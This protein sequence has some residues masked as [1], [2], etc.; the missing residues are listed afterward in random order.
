[1][2]QLGEDRVN[3]HALAYYHFVGL[4]G[5]VEMQVKQALKPFGLTHE[6]LN[7]LYA[8]ERKHPEKIHVNP[9]KN[10]LLVNNPDITRILDR[11]ASK[12]YLKREICPENRRKMDVSITE[13]GREVFHQ[14]H[15][16]ARASVGDFFSTFINREEALDLFRILKKVHL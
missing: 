6:Q 15:R 9:L 14:A 11:L 7:I 13:Q 12:G 3:P 16:A 1:M 2:I 10:A 4:S 5:K 8:L